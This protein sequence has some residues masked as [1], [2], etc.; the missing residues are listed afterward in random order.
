MRAVVCNELGPPSSLVVEERPDLEPSA[1][2][3]IVDVEAAGV[4]Y[5]DGLFVAGE[6]QIKPPLP[7]VPGNEVAGT[8]SAVADDVTRWKVGDRVLASVGLGGFA[9]AVATT[10]DALAHVPDQMS[11][12]AA[13][14]F[15]QSY[16]TVAFALGRRSA[17]SSGESLLVLGAAGGVGIAAIQ[18]GKAL[19]A[20]V[21]AAASSDERLERCTVAGADE[22]INYSEV[23]LK[24]AARELSGGGVDVVFDPVGH[25][26]TE[27][28]L[29]AM[30]EFGR[31]CVIGFA[32]GDIPKL[33]TNQVLL[34]NRS[35]VGVDWGAWAMGH[36]R[37][38]RVLLSDTLAM[39]ETGRLTP[40]EPTSYP[41]DR[42]GDALSDLLEHRLV[43]KAVL[44]P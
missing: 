22:T 3:V 31:L 12:A 39:V 38:Q 16:C 11:S 17:L 4:N 33:P 18:Y 40:P 2:Q 21:I 32:R 19:G 13:A 36:G 43:G 5:V 6:Y 37:E 29:R 25:D 34:R 15:T 24:T 42:V 7:F 20:T 27:P 44:V 8:I 41:L 28:A 14:A 23:D 35:V 9:S 1:G 30:G 10:P 26:L